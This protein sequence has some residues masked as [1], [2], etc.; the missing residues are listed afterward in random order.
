MK[1]PPVPAKAVALSCCRWPVALV[2]F[3]AA[4]AACGCSVPATGSGDLSVP[5]ADLTVPLDFAAPGDAAPPECVR[6]PDCKAGAP[7]CVDFH[8]VA[9]AMNTDCRS[10]AGV[11][12]CCGHLCVDLSSSNDD[13]GACGIACPMGQACCG[14]R[15][16]DV[17]NDATNC[18]KCGKV[19][20]P[21]VHASPWCTRGLCST[22]CVPPWGACGG[23][24]CSCDTMNSLGCCG[25][26][27][28]GGCFP[29]PHG[30]P[31]CAGGKC[32]IAT[33]DAGHADC[34]GLYKDGCEASIDSDRNNCGACGNVCVSGNCV[35]GQCK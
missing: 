16:L 33:C 7:R 4:L 2:A 8:C 25:G 34:N 3:A 14:G 21:A 19:C 32:A 1:E 23:E 9:C 28:G 11:S 29:L 12:T 20:P 24:D 6:D 35:G 17:Q 5:V 15:C 27:A 22:S 26:C 18:G 13:C 30:Q 31:K 10:D